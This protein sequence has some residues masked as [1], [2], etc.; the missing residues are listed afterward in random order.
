VTEHFANHYITQ[1]AAFLDDDDLTCTVKSVV[2]DPATPYRAVIGRKG[3]YPEE[4]VIV[5]NV[6]GNVLTISA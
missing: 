6:T 3:A 5:T 2:G 1:L 4:V